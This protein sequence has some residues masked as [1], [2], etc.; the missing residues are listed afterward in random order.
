MAEDVG[1]T[2]LGAGDTGPGAG[3]VRGCPRVHRAEG[4]EQPFQVCRRGCWHHRLLSGPPE[5]AQHTPDT[6]LTTSSDQTPGCSPVAILFYYVFIYS[7]FNSVAEP[8]S[9]WDLSSLTGD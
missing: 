2:G 6:T 3:R 5:L 4:A 1:A 7:F 8:C 9:M